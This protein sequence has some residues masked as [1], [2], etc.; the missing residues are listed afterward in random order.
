MIRDRLVDRQIRFTRHAT[1]EAVLYLSKHLMWAPAFAREIKAL[2]VAACFLNKVI[3]QRLIVLDT[4]TEHK[5][6]AEEN[7]L[8]RPALLCRRDLSKAFAIDSV[9]HVGDFAAIEEFLKPGRRIWNRQRTDVRRKLA[10][11]IRGG[12][13]DNDLG[14]RHEEQAELENS[15]TE[16]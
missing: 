8:M 16:Q 2:K 5:R 10:P 12:L 14:L 15:Q 4:V 7:Y 3:G 13:C 1:N 11:H 9:G 6:I